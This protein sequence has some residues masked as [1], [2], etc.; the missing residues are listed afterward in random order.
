MRNAAA[1]VA[2]RELQFRNKPAFRCLIERVR[3]V[4]F[5]MKLPRN[6]Q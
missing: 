2:A 3:K 1:E 4:H 5:G 6:I